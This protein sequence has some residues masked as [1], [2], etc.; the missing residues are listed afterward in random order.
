MNIY[1]IFVTKGP[2]KIY[3]IDSTS[4]S[5]AMAEYRDGRATFEGINHDVEVTAQK[6]DYSMACTMF[7]P[8]SHLQS[9]SMKK[10]PNSLRKER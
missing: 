8:Q 2:C 4:A 9:K 1:F 5:N 3:S 10:K 7:V 6:E